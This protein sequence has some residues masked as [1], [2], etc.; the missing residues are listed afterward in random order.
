[1]RISLT[2]SGILLGTQ[3]LAQNAVVTN[4]GA[5]P[6]ALNECSGLVNDG[7]GRFWMHADSY[8]ES[9]FYLVDTTRTILRTINVIN[10]QNIDWEDIAIDPD[11]N[12]YLADI[13]NNNNDR[14]DLRIL[15]VSADQLAG[16][17]NVDAAVINLSYSDQLAYPPADGQKLFDAE[18]MIFHNDSLHIFTKDRTSPYLG[19][20]RHYVCPTVE[21]NYVLQPK[22]TYAIGQFG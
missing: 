17:D 6:A 12:V 16:A 15:K 2:I 11:G 20:T 13:G 5:L 7:Q 3:L 1:M 10:A 14:T 4:L 18:A 8:N 9:K 22:G 21:G 19:I